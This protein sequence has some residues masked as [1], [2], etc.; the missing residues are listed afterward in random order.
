MILTLARHDRCGEARTLL[1]CKV[2]PFASGG[3]RFRVGF[4]SDL[5]RNR[6]TFLIM[7]SSGLID[8]K[9]RNL[10]ISKPA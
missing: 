3:V 8:P 2:S 4:G 9:T 7:W 5:S 1:S 6:L 10:N